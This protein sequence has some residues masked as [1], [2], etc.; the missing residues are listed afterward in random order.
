MKKYKI[1]GVF[2]GQVA[3]L[4]NDVESAIIKHP[5]SRLNIKKESID[6]DE[7]ANTKYHGG[8]MRVVHH[9]SQKNYN[10]LKEKFPDIAGRFIPGSFGENILTEELTEDELNIGDI[11]QLGAAKVQLTVSRRPCA[12]INY[13]YNDDR[14]LKEVMLTGRTGWFYQVLEEGVVKSGDYLQFIERPFPNMPVSKLFDQGYGKP[15]HYTDLKF[16]KKCL[17]TGL[18]DKGWKPKLDHALKK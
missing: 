14:I 2:T 16:L 11:Y 10:H 3:P 17:E 18:M 5:V 8:D 4:S 6:H 15:P 7:V 13:A 12:T 9:Y 1:L